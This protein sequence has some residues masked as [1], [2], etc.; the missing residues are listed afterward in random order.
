MTPKSRNKLNY[1][2]LDEPVIQDKLIQFSR[3]GVS[4]TTLFLPQIHCSACVWLLENL[5]KLDQGILF[6]R[7]NFL[8]KE[9]QIQF[10]ENRSSLRKIVELI[11]SIGYEPDFA[12]EK[13]EHPVPSSDRSLH[14]KLGIAGFSFGNIML[15]SLPAYL[16]GGELDQQFQDI[17]SYLNI[18]LALPLLY[19]VSSYFKSAWFVLR[20]KSF[21]MDVPISL[22]ISVLILRSLFEILTQSGTGFLDSLAGL[23]FFLLI[24]K[25]FQKKTFQALSF[26]RDYLSYFPL[27]IR[28][29]EGQRDIPIEQ[30]KPGDRLLI[31]HG[32]LVPA[33][34]V[35]VSDGA[36]IDYSFVTGESE[37]V[38]VG[39]NDRIF[40]GGKQM[41]G[42]IEIEAIHEVS[43]SYLMQLWSQTSKSSPHS[44]SRISSLVAQ[45]FTAAIITIAALTLVYWMHVGGD[46]ALEAV[47]SVLIV[48]CG[49]GLPLSIP[50]TN[51]TALRLMSFNGLFLKNDEVIERL[52]KIDT[53][54]FDKTGTLTESRQNEAIYEGQPLTDEQTRMIKSLTQNSTHPLS[55]RIS[56]MF[57]NDSM[58]VTNYEEV[59]GKGLRGMVNGVP[60]QVGQFGQ[61][62]G[63]LNRASEVPVTI[64][65]ELKG[66]FIIQSTLRSG[67]EHL[68]KKL[69]KRFRIFVLSGDHETEKEKLDQL[70]GGRAELLFRQMPHDKADFIKSLQNDGRS[71]MMVG[72]GLNDAGALK[73][74]NVGIAATEN[75][76]SF[77][78][79]SDGILDVNRLDMLPGFVELARQSRRIVHAA[80]GLIAIYNITAISMAVQ[81][82]LTPMVSA[83]IM[84]ISSISVVAFTVGA[85]TL[86]A[87]QLQLRVTKS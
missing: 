7:V 39:Q 19:C 46:R 31:R 6:S 25:T 37:P 15:L 45:Y 77:T 57:E 33:D 14:I 32:E 69:T 53:I 61:T 43:Q 26:D 85:V 78:P 23:T 35:L 70:F 18:L 82:M 84:P 12:R 42:Q 56:E 51:G 24:G 2:F 10:N 72:D 21:N 27:S 28:R 5:P 11:G 3:N 36:L 64:D 48:A 79:S 55:R 38:H 73:Q 52:S 16:S 76:S 9:L 71:V 65:G 8:K 60:V 41:G 75:T 54:V 83:I 59:P 4:R 40:A 47:T 20:A 63:S 81:G 34:S 67:A 62:A 68:A 1:E 50:F 80:F 86:R 66:K 13:G 74:S 49:C 22:G 87:K 29:I 30:I 17:F 58:K 44:M